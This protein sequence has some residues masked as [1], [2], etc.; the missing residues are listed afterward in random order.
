[1]NQSVQWNFKET[2]LPPAACLKPAPVTGPDGC[3]YEVHLQGKDSQDTTYQFAR[4]PSGQFD[5]VDP[6]TKDQLPSDH[7]T[8]LVTT[9]RIANA[10]I[11][12]PNGVS[13]PRS[14][15]VQIM[16]RLAA[17]VESGQNGGAV[18]KEKIELLTLL[19]HYFTNNPKSEIWIRTIYAGLGVSRGFKLSP[20]QV[21][22]IQFLQG[23]L[24]YIPDAE[25]GINAF[26]VPELQDFIY[27]WGSFFPVPMPTD[28]ETLSNQFDAFVDEEFKQQHITQAQKDAAKSIGVAYYPIQSV[29]DYGI[30]LLV[31]A[32]LGQGF[33]YDESFFKQ[34]DAFSAVID[35]GD[36]RGTYAKRAP[37]AQVEDAVAGI[38]CNSLEALYQP[39]GLSP[40]QQKNLKDCVPALAG[41]KDHSKIPHWQ[42]T[43]LNV[44][45]TPAVHAAITQQEEAN[46]L[47]GAVTFPMEQLFGT[48]DKTNLMK[49]AIAGIIKRLRVVKEKGQYV[50]LVLPEVAPQEIVNGFIPK[51]TPNNRRR[52]YLVAVR[53]FLEYMMG[54]EAARTPVRILVDE[55]GRFED[56]VL[57]VESPDAVRASI[58][59][60]KWKAQ[61][62]ED[63]VHLWTPLGEG[64]LAAAG[65]ALYLVGR[66]NGNEAMQYAGGAVAGVGAGGFLGH[67]V[68]NTLDV[69]GTAH[70]EWLPHAGGALLGGLGLSLL[71]CLD[72]GC[73]EEP[74]DGDRGGTA[75]PAQRNWEGVFGP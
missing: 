19:L 45:S 55:D 31:R 58:E 36:S 10:L 17:A 18:S 32:K 40:E 22:N 74:N 21:A 7:F 20:Q 75:D 62:S 34:Y 54:L 37:E 56:A 5:P 14:S 42:R 11:A 3:I 38:Y 27:Q 66:S 33:S 61:T 26:V 15:Q 12:A 71:V 6:K 48:D 68:F 29:Y 39:I 52:H 63:A 8:S 46:K 13:F 9:L 2:P 43:L 49:P 30:A 24:T 4:N 44:W 72:L 53:A 35:N 28:A 16:L 64:V 67:F 73:N 69:T 51:D 41:F 50:L 57:R 23:A 59:E 47:Q 25:Q 70:N 1:M 60:L 65:T